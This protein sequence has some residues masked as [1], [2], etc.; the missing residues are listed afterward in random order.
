MPKTTAVNKFLLENFASF[1]K[2]AFV[3]LYMGA[4]L[5]DFIDRCHGNG[6]L[7]CRL[8]VLVSKCLKTHKEYK[9]VCL[10]LSF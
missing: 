10:F 5:Q 1:I 6:S 4:K 2:T 8:H 3:S 9:I 7:N